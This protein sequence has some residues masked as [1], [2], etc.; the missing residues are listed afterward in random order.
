MKSH[1][2]I[3][4][5]FLLWAAAACHSSDEPFLPT[6]PPA[7][8]G[9]MPSDAAPRVLSAE[10]VENPQNHLSGFLE[11]RTDQA[12]SVRVEVSHES[13]TFTLPSTELDTEHSIAV[14]G[15][16]AEARFELEAT[17]TDSVGR[18]V[19]HRLEHETGA[20]PED[21]PTM[22]LLSPEPER[23]APGLTMFSVSRWKRFLE[24]DFIDEEWGMILV[25]DELG[26]VVWYH[27]ADRSITEVARLS[28]G[29][30]VYVSGFDGAVEIDLLGREIGRWT[31]DDLDM[32]TVHHDFIETPH[33]TFVSLG[34]ELRRIAGYDAM[35]TEYNVVGDVV[36]EFRRD[37]TIVRQHHLFDLLDPLRTRDGFE[38][39]H[40]DPVYWRDVGATKDW[41]HTNSVIHDPSDDSLILCLR[42][43][44]WL[45]KIDRETGA[46]IWRFGEDGDFELRSGGDFPFHS[47]SPELQP[48]GNLLVYDN[49]NGRTSSSEESEFSRAVEYALNT[50]G[51][52]GTWFAEQVWEFRNGSYFAPSVGDADRLKNGNV[53]ITDGGMFSVPFISMGDNSAYRFARIVEVT[54]ADSPDVVFQLIV[55]DTAPADRTGYTV[56]RADRI[57]KSYLY[58]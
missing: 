14:V 56:Y 21:I 31:H 20:L 51:P 30:I 23:T 50:D 49:G 4:T 38:E 41:S 40:W 34:T 26:R 43:Q 27:R 3:Q 24:L 35:G 55:A 52:P 17:L 42:H 44:D 28:G 29:S 9:S 58:R 39:P 16:Y 25:V 12:T 10:F 6:A 15:L 53:L 13:G 1:R 32:D 47:H 57:P 46:V 33:G 37:G 2:L 8:L 48:N 22:R 18:Q 5:L 11:V 19:V 36:A 45:L 54:R 7:P